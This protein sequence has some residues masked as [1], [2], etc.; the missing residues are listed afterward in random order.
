MARLEIEKIA[1]DLAAKS[2]LRLYKIA[3]AH[4][5]IHL[6][7]HGKTPQAL[8]KFLKSFAGVMAKRMRKWAEAKGKG[9]KL[10]PKQSF[11]SARPYSTL[12][13]FG[14]HLRNVLKY[15]EKNRQEALGFIEYT[16]RNHPIQKV[17]EKI[18]E[19]LNKHHSRYSSA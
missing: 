8:A 6:L 10:N 19:R 15:L 11:W 5:H 17:L 14:K 4:N 7:V 3:V 18:F 13:R 12:V 2:N 9:L 16:E 1:R